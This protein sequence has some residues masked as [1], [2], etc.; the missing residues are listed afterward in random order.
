[1][2]EYDYE[3]AVRESLYDWLEQEG[4]YWDA[5]GRLRDPYGVW[6]DEEDLRDAVWAEDDVTGNGPLEYWPGEF[7]W[8]CTIED[9]VTSNWVHLFEIILAWGIG[10]Q[11]LAQNAA[12]GFRDFCVWADIILRL[13]ALDGA[14][15]DIFSVAYRN[16]EGE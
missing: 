14:I 3:V 5:D 15:Y 13:D 4:W 6:M 7:P 9:A 11:S 10:G 16:R 2:A 12:N 1:M 8:N